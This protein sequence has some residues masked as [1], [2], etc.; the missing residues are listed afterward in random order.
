MDKAQKALFNPCPLVYFFKN[1]DG[2]L[3][4]FD[5]GKFC[6][7]L[8]LRV[9]LFRQKKMDM[10]I[11]FMISSSRKIHRKIFLNEVFCF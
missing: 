10:G 2:L 9:C 1:F 5:E 3:A 11:L 7:I 8:L 6:S 4:L